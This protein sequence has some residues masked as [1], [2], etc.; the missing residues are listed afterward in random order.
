MS[1]AVVEALRAQIRAKAPFI[2][3]EAGVSSGVSELDAWI[4]GLPPGGVTV[5]SG[6]LGGGATRLAARVLAE[7]TR[8]GAPVAW[9]DAAGTLY[10]PAL[11]QAGVDLTRLLLVRR[12]DER[13]V[14]A[15]EQL[16]ES[17]LFA[18]TVATGLDR[19]LTPA[20]ARRIQQA[21]EAGRGLA[22]LVLRTP[23]GDR[24]PGAVLRLAMQGHTP[25]GRL[26]VR[27]ET[28]RRG[29][30]PGAARDLAL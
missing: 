14:F 16:L 8:V 29:R 28:D 19:Q 23:P 3:R 2:D 6:A 13:A 27:L 24:M 11:E 22:L 4:R 15:C 1:S 17:G 20:R 25:D 12:N 26:R 21:A 18:A 30:P 9:V 5:L 10:P 7:R